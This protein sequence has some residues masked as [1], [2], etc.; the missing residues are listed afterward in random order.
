VTRGPFRLSRNPVFFGL[1][2]AAL[3]V[4]LVIPTALA[5][6]LLGATYVAI[7]TQV[8]LEEEHLRGLHGPDYVAYCAAVPRWLGG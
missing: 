8:R 5:W 1:L 7:S 4:A 3:G 2:V 6:A